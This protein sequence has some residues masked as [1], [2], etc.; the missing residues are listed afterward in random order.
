MSTFEHI[1]PGDGDD[2]GDPPVRIT[3]RPLASPLPLGFFAFAIGSFVFTA[4]ELGWV[5]QT[6]A[7]QAALVMLVFVAPLELLASVLA[8]WARDPGGATALGL[9]GMTW[10]V[11]GAITLT[12]TAPRSPVAGVFLLCVSAVILA[13]GATSLPSKPV[14]SLVGVVASAR[15]L[16]TGVYEIHSG[17]GWR[18]ASGWVGLPLAACAFYL[19]LALM[20][21]DAQHRT[22]RPLL[23]RGE[24]RTAIESHLAD[25]TAAVEREAGVRGQL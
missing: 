17:E 20:I 25:Q 5:P 15:F 23:R 7:R 14:L 2:R 8:F 13:F 16:L 21:E 6:P 4:F 24:A 19:A 12:S 22:V 9:F 1:G 10:G 11:V 3:L 18:H